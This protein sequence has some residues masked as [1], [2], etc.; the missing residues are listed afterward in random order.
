LNL[1][2]KAISIWLAS[3][4]VAAVF[5]VILVGSVSAIS[6]DHNLSGIVWQSDGSPPTGP[7]DFCIWVEHTAGSDSWYRFP[8]T[9]WVQTEQ[10][11]DGLWW[12]SFVL[13]YGQWGLTWGDTDNY[14]VHVDGSPWGEFFGNTTSNGTGSLG[15]PFPPYDPSN[16]NSSFNQI[17]YAPGGGSFNEQ[18]W[19]VRTVAPIDLAPTNVTAMGMIPSLFPSGMPAAPNTDLPIYFNVTN[20]GTVAS[21]PFFVSIWNCTV[22][23]QNL[24]GFPID[25]WQ[26]P[27]L[28]GGSD[29]PV[30]SRNWYANL[31]PGDYYVNI[32]V[33]SKGEITE[34]DESNNRIILHFVVGPELI[35]KDVFINGNPIADPIYVGP[36]TQVVISA[37]VQNIG[38]SPTGGPADTFEVTLYNISWPSQQPIGGTEITNVVGTLDSMEESAPLTWIW[39][40]PTGIPPIDAWVNI[41]VDFGDVV[42]EANEDNNDVTIHLN[43]PDT[44]VTTIQ[45]TTPVYWDGFVWYVDSTTDLSFEVD[46]SYPPFVI[47]YRILDQFTGSEVRAWNIISE[48]ATFNMA[49]FGESTYRIEYYSIDSVPNTEPTN[50]KIIIVDD[51]DP[52]STIGFA[53][54]RYRGSPG[55]R[56]NITSAT[57]IT[58]TAVDLPLG[59]S[60]Q[61]GF[62]NAS[63][64]GVVGIDLDIFYRVTRQSDALVVRAWTQTTRF[65]EIGGVYTANQ[66]SFNTTWTDGLYSIEYYAIDN[67]GHTETVNTEIVNLDNTAP[68]KSINYDVP[69]YRADAVNDLLN[70]SSLSDITFTAD[71][72][73]GSGV[74]RTEYR[75]WDPFSDTGWVTYT[76]AFTISSSWSDGIYTIQ[77][78]STDNLGNDDPVSENFY[79]DNTGPDSDITGSPWTLKFPNR[80]EV[81]MSTL[82]TMSADDGE[83]SGVFAIEYRLDSDTTWYS[84]SNPTNFTNLFPSLTPDEIPWNH[85]I[86]VRAIDNLN[87]IGPET[88]QMIFIEGD[89]TPPLPPVLRV[90][91]DGDNLRLDWE[92]SVSEDIAYYLIYRSTSKMAFDFTSI[93]VNTVADSDGG[94]IPLRTTWNDAGAGASTSAPEYYYTI[95]GVDDRG[96]VGYTSN[97]A[98]KTTLTFEHGYNTFSLPL[99]PFE[100]M[101]GS[102]MLESG[103]FEDTSDTVYR[104]DQ[105]TQQWMGHTKDMPSS[106]DDFILTFGEGYMI[107]VQ[108]A[109]AMVTFTGAAGTSIRFT[110]GVGN[111]LVFQDSLHAN[112]QAN[113]VQLSWSPA[114]G[115]TGYAVYRGTT[116]LG[117]DSLNDFSLQAVHIVIGTGTSWT[118]T[119]AVGSEYYYL[120]VAME[121][122]QEGSSSYAVGVK[123]VTLSDGYSLVSMELAPKIATGVG[124]FSSNMFSDDSGTLFYYDKAIGNW[125]GHPRVLPENINNGEI[126]T[127]LAYIVYSEAE[128]VSYAYTGV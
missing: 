103:D 52:L 1:K 55:D 42:W 114:S 102:Q 14:K 66:I 25:E 27:S 127:G 88:A 23:G 58:L 97:I 63:G 70:I 77:Y 19:D 107:Y 60:P 122:T 84:Y 36:G 86:Y 64:I 48:G 22:T 94:I 65:S 39:T 125:R 20:F 120:I 9:G 89:T 57:P 4:L 105:N 17:N 116:R 28:P 121:G 115:A 99:A 126:N 79:L 44:P 96:N 15:D 50:N 106:M 110:E 47:W 29:S 37:V 87:N 113:Q 75:V 13:P 61:V 18:Q 67:L 123:K 68:V 92:P 16:I 40:A 33:D 117:S 38:P 8:S 21:G 56:L 118:D 45:S 93:Y 101:T 3:I 91:L 34:F 76:G 85:T 82:F 128:D 90:F 35:I 62:L 74:N 41:T 111:E 54:P 112:A 26:I 71:D 43:V 6:D 95:R 2:R 80:Y 10:G 104:Y 49:P 119:T 51:T 72:G 46:G 78:N 32:T 30:Q 5:T 24:P 98:G 108:E 7:S 73:L 109:S 31:A 11:V 12:Y 53:S 100:D 69:T 81:T 124:R 83:G 59:D